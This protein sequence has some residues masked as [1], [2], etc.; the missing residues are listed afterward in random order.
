[1][2]KEHRIVPGW[3]FNI[4]VGQ[5]SEFAVSQFGV[6][7]DYL[8]RG[9]GKRMDNI[10]QGFLDARL[11]DLGEE[12]ERLVWV[13]QAADD[14]AEKLKLDRRALLRSA[15]LLLD[16]RP[17]NEP[18]FHLCE[19]AVKTHWPTYRSRFSN[20]P[21]QLFKA[22]LIQAVATVAAQPDSSYMAIVFYAARSPS[23][24]KLT[25]KDKNILS[26]F[27]GSL[28]ERL[29]AEATRKWTQA[30]VALSDAAQSSSAIKVS[31]LD[32][33]A[34]VVAF[35][36]AAGP[37]EGVKG[38]NPQWPGNSPEWLAHFSQAAAEA[39][40]T[41]L[42]AVL[43]DLAAKIVTKAK[44]DSAK[45]AS[46]LESALRQTDSGDNL[47]AKLLYWKEAL[48]SATK[49]TSYRRLSA[50]A[51]TYWAAHDLQQQLPLYHPTS[52]E[53]FL[54]EGLRMA[55]GDA[56][57]CE[58]ATLQQFSSALRDELAP[59]ALWPTA[60]ANSERLTLLE[61]VHGVAGGHIRP[62]DVAQRTGIPADTRVPREELTV[63]LLRDLQAHRLA[64][65]I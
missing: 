33:K 41:G 8:V 14:L 31:A 38:A 35:K 10:L 43:Q 26:S 22:V 64:G 49:K 7:Y 4:N 6:L 62:E 46:M 20:K 63:W 29:E 3:G 51:A 5:L 28:G 52:V 32:K 25:G 44:D 37:A 59:G 50:D 57:V 11:L 19:E 15:S 18:I 40:D 30:N 47:K 58:E 42:T 24:Y 65:G 36:G 21:N 2:V 39:I 56:A 60:V 55:L 34:L 53:F 16:D 54:G 9:G 61:A 13:K 1:M 45:L 27:L 17:G 48:Y 12:P 23:Q